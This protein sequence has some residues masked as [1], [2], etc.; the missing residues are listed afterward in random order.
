MEEVG[1]RSLSHF[2][3]LPQLQTLLLASNRIGEFAEVDKLSHLQTMIYFS[4]HNNPV[5]RKH[6]YRPLVLRKL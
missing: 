6:L 1:L 2:A 4:L 5:A 3:P